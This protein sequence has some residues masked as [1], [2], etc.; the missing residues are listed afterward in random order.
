MR[1]ILFFASVPGDV[2]SMLRTG[3]LTFLLSTPPMTLPAEF[4]TLPSSLP[5]AFMFPLTGISVKRPVC[6]AVRLDVARDTHRSFHRYP[7]QGNHEWGRP[8]RW[9][10]GH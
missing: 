7:S 6:V 5:R 3:S 4:L 10:P 9:K 1:Q 2:P 8:T